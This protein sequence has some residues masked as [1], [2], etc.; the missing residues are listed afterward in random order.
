MNAAA[1]P[2]SFDKLHLVVTLSTLASA[3]YFILVSLF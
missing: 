2:L 1:S 3:A